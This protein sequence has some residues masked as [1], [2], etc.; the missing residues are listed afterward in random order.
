MEV[1][2]THV[3]PALLRKW[4][5][6]LAPAKQ[7]FY[8]TAKQLRSWKL[9]QDDTE[10]DRQQRDTYLT[11]HLDS[12]LRSVCLDE[13]TFMSLPQA[14]RA[15]MVRAQVTH[16]RGAVPSVRRWRAVL[17]PELKAQ[18]D[19]HRFVWWK[20]LLRGSRAAAVLPSIVGEGLHPSRHDEVT[21]WPTKLLPQARALAGTWSTTGEANCFGTVLAATG[22]KD[23]VETW[24]QREPFEQWL[25][26]HTESGG[27]DDVPGTVFV[28]RDTAEGLV[29]HAGV[30]LGGGYMLHKPS[31][32]WITRREVRTVAEVRRTTRGAGWRLEK[33]ALLQ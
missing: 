26:A 6:W 12:R 29:Q 33:R 20:P 28:W 15:A 3:S 5:D 2:G 7:P 23:A 24:M 9:Q 18:A 31:Q 32:Q 11:Y 14:T 16:E 13:E 25:A 19:G 22:V 4:V 8:G 27:R 17:G 1:L 30:T 10:P 21:A